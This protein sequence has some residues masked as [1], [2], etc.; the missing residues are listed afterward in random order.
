LR[1]SVIVT[2]MSGN[3]TGGGVWR[4]AALPHHDVEEHDQVEVEAAQQRI[5]RM[6]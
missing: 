4:G 1:I 3:V 5:H 2:A 6:G